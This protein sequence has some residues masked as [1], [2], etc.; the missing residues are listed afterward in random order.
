MRLFCALANPHDPLPALLPAQP[1]QTAI[2]IALPPLSS[3][4]LTSGPLNLPAGSA[5]RV[6][7]VLLRCILAQRC[8]CSTGTKLPRLGAA[9][10]NNRQRVVAES[11]VE[12]V[13]IVVAALVD[14]GAAQAD[15]NVGVVGWQTR[16]PI[17]TLPTK[18]RQ[19]AAEAA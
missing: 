8:R 9:A 16:R 19:G 7:P 17:F 2:T 5:P 13:A 14:L 18:C 10:R 3:P 15:A 11:P 6:A 12:Q 4:V 1:R